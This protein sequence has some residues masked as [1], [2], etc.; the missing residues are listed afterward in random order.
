MISLSSTGIKKLTSINDTAS[1][2]TIYAHDR[3]SVAIV[4]NRKRRLSKPE[5]QAF[6]DMRP[7]LAWFWSDPGVE[8]GNGR[9]ITLKQ[10]P[11]SPI[12]TQLKQP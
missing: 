5:F 1:C 10:D 11:D 6:R 9:G 8:A 12:L 3:G 4:S 7:E 2:G